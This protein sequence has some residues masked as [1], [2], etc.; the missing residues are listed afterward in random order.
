MANPLRILFAG[1]PAIA[2][3]SLRAIA[4]NFDVVGVLTNPDRPGARGK[5]LVPSPVKEAA[6]ELGLHV[7][8]PERLLGDARR[9]IADTGADF[10]V[11]FA[12]GRLFGPKFLSL[13]SRGAVNIH[14]SA[15]PRHRG[16]AP[17]QYTI[18]EG[19]A[20][21]AVS[22]QGI[23]SEMD[24][25]D[26]YLCDTFPL[27]GTETTASLTEMVSV[28]AAD[29]IIGVLHGIEDGTLHA[30]PQQGSPTF[31]RQLEKEDGAIDWNRSASSIH[32]QVRAM[33]PWPKATTLFHGVPLMI[34]SVV[35]PVADAGKESV[36]AQVPAGTVVCSRKGVGIAI[37]TADGLLW[38]DRLQ[39][40]TKKELDWQ[41]FLNGNPTFVG[42]VLG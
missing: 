4:S 41:S 10:L 8:Q 35:G 2:V 13:F 22:I 36:P 32:C 42:S 9:L 3:P 20:Q 19:D 27:S 23:A 31:T 30:T 14:P 15:L 29:D 6:L 40:A 38:V 11:S 39:L 18:W 7:L 34:T 21:G 37:A 1:T 24:C 33:L 28:R 26:L 12:Y 25:G 5:S 16:S 17:I